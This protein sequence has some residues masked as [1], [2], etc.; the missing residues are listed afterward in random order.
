MSRFQL[1][2][3]F[4]ARLFVAYGAFLALWLLV[5]SWYG[6]VF[7]SV[8]GDVFRD[9]GPAGLVKFAPRE[10]PHPDWDS[11]MQIGNRQTK[12]VAAVPF[13]T[14]Y[15]G[16]APTIMLCSLVLATPVPWGRRF[17]A[18]GLG[19]VLVH[20]F[21]AMGVYLMLLDNFSSGPPLGMYDFS[22]WFKRFV[23][24]L[25]A[26][27]TQSTTTRYAVP[28]VFWILVTIRP[29]DVDRWRTTLVES[30]SKTAGPESATRASHRPEQKERNRRMRRNA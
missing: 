17:V 15:I 27:F 28:T 10:T 23:S 26:T 30:T 2:G 4:F 3:G 14:K 5:G 12:Q 24:F 11:E 22:P 9:F 21:I 7:R 18:L 25:E 20:F 8:A 6:D 16:Y 19:L 29:R 1:V 13:G